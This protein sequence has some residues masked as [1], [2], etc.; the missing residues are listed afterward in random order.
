[1][2]SLIINNSVTLKPCIKEDLKELSY[3][4]ISE[5]LT[6]EQFNRTSKEQI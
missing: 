4:I 5:V 6:K 3:D 1:M 2:K